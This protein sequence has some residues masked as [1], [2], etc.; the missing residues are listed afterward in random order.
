[1]KVR[2]YVNVAVDGSVRFH[3]GRISTDFSDGTVQKTYTFELEVPHPLP[4]LKVDVST[5]EEVK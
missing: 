5:V 4:E 3:N 1:M 2:G